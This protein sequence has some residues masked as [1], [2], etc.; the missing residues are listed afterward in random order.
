MMTRIAMPGRMKMLPAVVMLF[1]LFLGISCSKAAPGRL[2]GSSNEAFQKSVK[3]MTQSLSGDK[4]QKFEEAMKFF[5]LRESFK[6]AFGGGGHDEDKLFESL[7]QQLGG[8][9]ADEVIAKADAIRNG[10]G[11]E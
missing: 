10:A 7:R 5:L 6:Q 8:L 9:T 1:L 4:R 3:E 11:K 2:D